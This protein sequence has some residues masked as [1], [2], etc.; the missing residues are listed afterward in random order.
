MEKMFQEL[1]R[2]SGHPVCDFH[3]LSTAVKIDLVFPSVASTSWS[4]PPVILPRY[5]HKLFYFIND[6][7]QLPTYQS[8][9]HSY[10][11]SCRVQKKAQ[12]TGFFGRFYWV[13]CCVGFFRFSIWWA[14]GKLVD[15]AHQSSLMYTVSQKKGTS[16]LLSITLANINRFS[17]FFHCW[18]WQ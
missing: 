9:N 2:K 18:I 6:A 13:L 17:N 11:L 15:L 10:S 12:P 7:N 4:M 3:Y 5:V 1:S 14:V 8:V 16:V